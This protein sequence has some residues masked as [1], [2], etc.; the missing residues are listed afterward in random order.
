MKKLFMTAVLISLLA[1]TTAVSAIRQ[2]TYTVYNDKRQVQEVWKES[3][4]D[5]IVIY[6]P[7]LKLKGYIKK[8]PSGGGVIYDEKFR[9]KGEIK[10]DNESSSIYKKIE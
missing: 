2:K 4:E 8:F 10:D 7:D 3:S 5:T 1:S 6:S 9:L